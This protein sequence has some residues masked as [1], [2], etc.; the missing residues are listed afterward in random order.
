[1]EWIN[2]KD[3]LPPAGE[4]VLATDGCFVTEAYISKKKI[5]HRHNGYSW[6]NFYVTDVRYW[7]PM[8]EPPASHIPDREG[9]E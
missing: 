1:M 8:P 4:R 7:M 6:K 3:K 9:T 5:W 2:V